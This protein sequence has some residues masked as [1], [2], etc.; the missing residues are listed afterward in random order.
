MSMSSVCV[1]ANALR[2]KLF[3]PRHAGVGIEAPASKAEEAPTIKKEETVMTKTVTIE[4]LMCQNC[5]KHATK[6]LNDLPGV[7]ATVDLES[8]TAVVTGE[9]S[10]EAIKAAIAEA[11]YEVT[12]IQ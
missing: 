12:N 1:V 6:A 11:G 5:V 4:G 7:T 2:L 9:V 8:K 10:D 3:K